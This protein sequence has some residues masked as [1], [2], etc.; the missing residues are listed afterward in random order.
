MKPVT[1]QIL[2]AYCIISLCHV[3]G[4][5]AKMEV[6]THITKPMLIPVL[7][8][9]WMH[10]T[11]LKTSFSLWI[12]AALI[13]CWLGDILLMEGSWFVYGLA[14]FLMGHIFYIISIMKITGKRAIIRPWLALPILVYLFALMSLLFP[15]LN[16]MKLPVVLYAIIISSF[17]L[18]CLNTF[19]K[20]TYRIALYLSVGAALFVLSDSILAINKFAVKIPLSGIWVMTTYCSAQYLLIFAAIQYNA[21]SIE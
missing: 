18:L 3:T 5:A 10:A 8:V 12:S 11:K 13:F 16:E 6:V 1:R 2:L 21:K 9:A 15:Y 7:L 19:R 4:I 17:L 20:T 14:D